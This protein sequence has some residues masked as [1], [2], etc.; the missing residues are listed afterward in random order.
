MKMDCK[1][2]E[3]SLSHDLTV[4]FSGILRIF[5]KYYLSQIRKETR[6]LLSNGLLGQGALGFGERAGR[7]RIGEREVDYLRGA[8]SWGSHN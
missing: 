6:F 1:C 4:V 8:L 3:E 2:I 5:A 7:G